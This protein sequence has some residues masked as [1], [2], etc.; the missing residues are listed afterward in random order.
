MTGLVS[1]IDSSKIIEA[2]L[3]QKK[4]PLQRMEAQKVGT[5][6]KISKVS[7]IIGKMNALKDQMEKMDEQS[8]VLKLT[9]TTGDEELLTVN[10]TGDAMPGSYGL[11]IDQLATHAKYRTDGWAS[12][13][14]EVKAGTLIIS[15]N[16]ADPEFD[17]AE[18]LVKITIDKG[19]TVAEVL[20]KI[21]DSGAEVNASFVF[22][23]TK[24][25]LQITNKESGFGRTLDVDGNPDPGTVDSDAAKALEI[26]YTGTGLTG[27]DFDFGDS[28]NLKDSDGDLVK[29]ALVTL[30]GLDMEFTEN[31]LGDVLDGVT[32]ELLEVGT[33]TF[34]VAKDKEGTKENVQ[35]FVDSYNEV[36]SLINRSVSVTEN[37]DRTRTLAGDTT[38]QHLKNALRDL[39]SG[40][41]DN[42]TG[43]FSALSHIG[44]TSSGSGTLKL[45]ADDLADALD[46]DMDSVGRLF[47]QDTDGL[48][49]LLIEKVESYTDSLDGIL[50]EKKDSLNDVIRNI[51]KRIF[52]LEDRIDRIEQQM[53]KKFSR[54]EVTISML[55]A[56]GQSLT[57]LGGGQ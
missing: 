43:N 18:D 20:D 22:D 32:L 46:A 56:Q 21:N 12:K 40:E 44:I 48:A 57:G 37:S 24:Y 6:S 17:P 41:L 9:G 51:D 25:H 50:I 23:G 26:T 53:V 29:N 19:D 3:A 14:D 35:A 36:I 52:R 10:A 39:I 49:D 28:G 8:E 30:D 33:T 1:G 47:S 15:V 42:M 5:K 54:M 31:S 55:Q 13:D 11:D 38:I 45:D 7:E 4:L 2:T 16:G 27:T 34:E